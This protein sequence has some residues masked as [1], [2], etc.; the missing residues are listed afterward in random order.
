M[1]FLAPVFAAI[2]SFFA[3]NAPTIGA[4]SGLA[5]A[6]TTV[7]EAIAHGGTPSVAPPSSTLAPATT[8]PAAPSAPQLSTAANAQAQTGGGVSPGYLSSLLQGGGFG[9]DQGVLNQLQGFVTQ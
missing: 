2:G 9:A 6:G 7:G 3:A 4:I 8:A 1:P 5:G